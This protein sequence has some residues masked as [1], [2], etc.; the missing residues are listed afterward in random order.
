V[1]ATAATFAPDGKS[2]LCAIIGDGGEWTTGSYDKTALYQIRLD[3]GSFQAV[4]IL[5]TDVL[6][7]PT[8]LS[9]LENNSLLIRGD[10]IPPDYPVQ[11]II[12]AA[13]ERFVG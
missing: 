1:I 9:W 11:I 5:K 3:D 4:R 6:E 2:L 10:G 8:K 7:T 13:F 12:P